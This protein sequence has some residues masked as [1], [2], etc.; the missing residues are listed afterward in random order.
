MEYSPLFK[1][2]AAIRLQARKYD[3]LIW[4]GTKE[5]SVEKALKAQKG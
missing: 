3:F 5:E 1:E 2:L 4:R